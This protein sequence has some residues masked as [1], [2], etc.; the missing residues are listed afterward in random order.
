[1]SKLYR[2]IGLSKLMSIAKFAQKKK[3]RNNL[4]RKKREKK[5]K[6]KSKQIFSWHKLSFLLEKYYLINNLLTII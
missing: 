3:K 4:G 2:K 5:S 6:Q 1:M